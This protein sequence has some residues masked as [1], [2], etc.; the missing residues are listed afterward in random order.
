MSFTRRRIREPAFR[1]QARRRNAE[2]AA[3]VLASITEARAL[4]MVASRDGCR[5]DSAGTKLVNDIRPRFSEFVSIEEDLV[6]ARLRAARAAIDHPREKGRALED[7]VHSLFGSQPHRRTLSASS[8]LLGRAFAVAAR[9]CFGI[10][11][12]IGC[13]CPIVVTLRQSQIFDDVPVVN[14]DAVR[15][16]WRCVQAAADHLQVHHQAARRAR[17]NDAFN[18]R[19]IDAVAHQKAV[20]HDASSTGL[21]ARDYFFAGLLVIGVSEHFRGDALLPE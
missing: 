14:D 16:A 4:I 1:H 7:Y 9:Q 5:I 21:E 2:T 19:Q 13:Q 15:L 8:C 11:V 18:C 3:T 20:D 6:K 17:E 12:A 10:H